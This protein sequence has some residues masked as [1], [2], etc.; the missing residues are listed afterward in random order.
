MT[1][2]ATFFFD[3]LWSGVVVWVVLYISDYSLTLVCARLYRQGVCDKI[4]FEGSFE[5]TP[6]FQADIDALRTVS[7]R[8]LAALIIGLVYLAA[9]RWLAAESQPG[10][11]EFVLGA[12]I[13]SELAIHVRH[14]RNLFLFRTIVRSEAIQGRIYYSRPIILQMSSVELLGF[15][16][17]FGVLAIFTSSWFLMGGTAACVGLALKHWRQASRQAKDGK[18]ETKVLQTATGTGAPVSN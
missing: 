17:L 6:Y 14:L 10:L 11:Y 8:F 18:T 3:N 13:S 15:S 16:V 2:V 5:L 1:S 12:A 4:A 9:I 7:P